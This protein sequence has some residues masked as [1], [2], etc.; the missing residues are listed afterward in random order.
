MERKEF[1][2]PLF[3]AT[4]STNISVLGQNDKVMEY[5][6][7]VSPKTYFVNTPEGMIVS[8][9]KGQRLNKIW[10]NRIVLKMSNVI[11][12]NRK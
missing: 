2:L 12:N 9:I 11:F 7:S 10:D 1:L 8:V 5:K 3:L 6:I 4:D